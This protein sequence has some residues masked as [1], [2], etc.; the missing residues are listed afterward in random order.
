MADLNPLVPSSDLKTN[1]LEIHTGPVYSV[2][3]QPGF[4]ALII[5]IVPPERDTI[6]HYVDNQAAFIYE[7]E[8]LEIVGVQIEAFERSF[9]PRHPDLQNIWRM[10]DA[11][12]DIQDFGDLAFLFE[13]IKPQLAR[14]VV[15]AT[16]DR[17]GPQGR[18]LIAAVA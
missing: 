11:S 14:E 12:L 15:Q 13:R 2:R 8:T 5:L 6:V 18:E 10:K 9:L 7:D 1:R 3:Y 16:S 4:D 17:L